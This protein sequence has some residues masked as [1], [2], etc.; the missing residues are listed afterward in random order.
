MIKENKI[1]AISRFQ[2]LFRKHS[3]VKIAKLIAS[4]VYI[5]KLNNSITDQRQCKV[6]CFNGNGRD[7]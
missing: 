2:Y 4:Y 5:T 3:S 6:I 1:N 7:T